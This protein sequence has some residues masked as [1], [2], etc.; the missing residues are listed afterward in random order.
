MRTQGCRHRFVAFAGVLV[1]A[2]LALSG[3]PARADAMADLQAGSEAETDGRWADAVKLVTQAI[4]SHELKGLDLAFAYRLRGSDY[5]MLS[6]RRQ[7]ADLKQAVAIVDS[8][9]KS[10]KLSGED[11]GR[12]YRRRGSANYDMA[13]YA[14]ALAD[15]TAAIKAD[16]E[17][18]RAHLGRVD[19][20]LQSRRYDLAM[21]DLEAA[22][23]IKPDE[24]VTHY[25][26]GLVLGYQGKFAESLAAYQMALTLSPKYWMAYWARGNVY[27]VTGDYARAIA[28]YEQCLSFNP[29]WEQ[30]KKARERARKEL[31]L[32]VKSVEVSDR[33]LWDSLTPPP[34]AVEQRR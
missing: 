6:D 5:R 3:A 21:P 20:Y 4:E 18:P 30:A 16:P 27:F 2:F 10:G 14:E 13:R 7:T 11:L 29:N 28:D 33:A 15:Y 34:A 17:S 22:L 8:E 32:G 1:C 26:L 9:I 23:K 25:E 19:V 31:L 12:A 24:P